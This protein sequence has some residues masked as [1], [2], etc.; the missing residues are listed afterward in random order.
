MPERI[1]KNPPLER[2]TLSDAQKLIRWFFE[3]HK[4]TEH[5]VRFGNPDKSDTD[6]HELKQS[7][8]EHVHS[9]RILA[10]YIMDHDSTASNLDRRRVLEMIDYHDLHEG[11]TGDS[12]RKTDTIHQAELKAEEHIRAVE[13]RVGNVGVGSID[14]YRARKSHEALFVKGVDRLEAYLTI[15]YGKNPN[16]FANRATDAEAVAQS[17]AAV[18][19]LLARTQL[20]AIRF[21]R[22]EKGAQK[23]FD[24]LTQH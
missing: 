19:P 3:L 21:L 13:A 23:E 9:M 14:E 20:L 24:F 7:L 8:P 22:K 16:A 2:P 1:S 11:I 6:I 5:I 4:P 12:V 15:M 10:T 18:S 17:V